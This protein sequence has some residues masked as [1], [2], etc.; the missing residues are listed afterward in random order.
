MTAH[1][2]ADDV[3]MVR[4]IHERFETWA[5]KRQIEVWHA[6]REFEQRVTERMLADSPM[7]LAALQNMAHGG[8]PD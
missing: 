3:A 6:A 1:S 2:Q 4:T 8:F 5:I 7:A